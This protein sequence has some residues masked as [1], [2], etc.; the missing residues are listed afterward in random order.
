[1]KILKT[2]FFLT[3]LLLLFAAP[4][5]AQNEVLLKEGTA[6]TFC[7]DA[8]LN[9]AD[10]ATN[11]TDDVGTDTC[12]CDLDHTGLVDGAAHASIKCDIDT[13]GTANKWGTTFRTF[14]AVDF[15]GETP[16]GA[17]T[18]DYYWCPSTSSTQATGNIAGNSGANAA[19]C[20]G[21]T[22][23][24]TTDAE[25]VRQCLFIGAF[26]TSDDATVQGGYVGTF[27]APT[28]HGQMV[29]FNNSGDTFEA[30]NVEAHVAIWPLLVEIQ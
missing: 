2:L 17:L 8:A 6:I 12:D 10:D 7:D 29:V 21:C 15:T 26:V 28:Q 18:V 13:G 24:G 5:F 25:F 20:D 4:V 11:Y 3:L 14:A 1:M 23:T 30:D 16:A 27:T 9:P 19:V 22:A